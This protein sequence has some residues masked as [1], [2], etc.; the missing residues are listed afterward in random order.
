MGYY[1]S[2]HLTATLILCQIYFK[3]KKFEINQTKIKG[4]C[5][6]GRKVVP[7]DSKSDLPLVLSSMIS[8][9][10]L[11]IFTALCVV[12]SFKAFGR[13]PFYSLGSSIFF[14]NKS[15]FLS[16]IGQFFFV[17]KRRTS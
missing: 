5:Q 12:V 8:A 7:H 2:Y 10:F 15:C 9:R 13:L 3:I 11:I 4:G 6:L 1:F 17:R 16:V 14:C